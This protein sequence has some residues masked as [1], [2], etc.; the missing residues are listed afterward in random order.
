MKQK[1]IDKVKELF[2]QG[3]IKGFVA[4]RQNGE[5][6][7]PY[8]FTD[9]AELSSLS[10][11]DKD[12]PGDARYPLVK[13]LARL[14]DQFPGENFALLARGCD[15]R[16]MWRLAAD[17]RVNPLDPDRVVVVGFSCPRELAE[18]C[19]CAKPWPDERVAGDET[20][21][22][23]APGPSGESADLVEQMDEWLDIMDRCLKCF[24]CRN[25]CPV[26]GCRECT[27]ETEILVPQR[28]LPP[29]PSFLMTRAMHMVDRCVYC[30]LCEQACPADIPLKKLYRLVAELAGRGETLPGVRPILPHPVNIFS[31]RRA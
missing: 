25:N 5:H 24:G 8:V 26:C 13:M 10:L 31:G 2:A 15:E 12:A 4:L 17:E 27:V 9:P 30:G 20:P 23:E 16:A 14:T 7:G 18:A 3:K 22:V 28:E 21:G 29:D 11:G 19:E 6:I 1:I